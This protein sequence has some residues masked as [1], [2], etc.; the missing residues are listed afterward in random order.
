MCTATKERR[1]V[2]IVHQVKTVPSYE[3]TQEGGSKENVW[4]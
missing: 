4:L 2:Y 3:P 1:V